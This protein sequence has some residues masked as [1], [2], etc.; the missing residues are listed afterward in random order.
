MEMDG[1]RRRVLHAAD[2]DDFICAA[3]GSFFYSVF[4]QLLFVLY[5]RL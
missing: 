3:F 1:Q 4:P 2:G 5:V